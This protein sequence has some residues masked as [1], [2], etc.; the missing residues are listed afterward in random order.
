MYKTNFSR[1]R[2]ETN[3]TKKPLVEEE[4]HNNENET[5]T[6]NEDGNDMGSDLV[7]DNNKTQHSETTKDFKKRKNQAHE[8]Q[9]HNIISR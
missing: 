9:N 1:R 4:Y 6:K 5:N 3:A 8:N 7:K 2:I